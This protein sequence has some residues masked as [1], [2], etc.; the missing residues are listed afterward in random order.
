MAGVVPATAEATARALR[1]ML[2]RVQPA[3]HGVTQKTWANLLSGFR[4]ALRLT[5]VIESRGDGLAMKDPSLGS[6]PQGHR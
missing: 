3:A 5:E 6:S 1:Q 2:K 4:A